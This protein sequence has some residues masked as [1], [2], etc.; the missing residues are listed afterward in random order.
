M[1]QVSIN[2]IS[3]QKQQSQIQ[4]SEILISDL[5]DNESFYRIR[6]HRKGTERTA[7]LEE[8]CIKLTEE[9][10]GDWRGRFFSADEAEKHDAFLQLDKYLAGARAKCRDVPKSDPT[11]G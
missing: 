11:S 8:A 5:R 9:L 1:F 2:N 3:H 10:S 4:M 6:Q 7:L